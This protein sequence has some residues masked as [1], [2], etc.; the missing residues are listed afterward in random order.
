VQPLTSP[1]F[2]HCGR[3]STAPPPLLA[4]DISGQ[5]TTANRL[6]VSPIAAQI[7]LF[8]S[9]GPTPL[10]VSSAPP[11]EGTIVKVF[12]CKGLVARGKGIFVKPKSF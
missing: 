9:S 2:E 10:T 7:H 3:A 11:S 12:M 1:E 6:G 8:A 5:G 4:G